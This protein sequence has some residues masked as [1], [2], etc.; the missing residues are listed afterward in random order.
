M[1]IS[2][3]QEDLEARAGLTVYKHDVCFGLLIGREPLIALA[4]AYSLRSVTYLSCEEWDVLWTNHVLLD[5]SD[6][7]STSRWICERHDALYI[8]R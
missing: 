1:L 3:G 4:R 8:S 2:E 6:G 5:G 7:I